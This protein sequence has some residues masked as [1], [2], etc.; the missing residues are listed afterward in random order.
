LSWKNIPNVFTFQTGTCLQD[1]KC[2]YW[3][4]ISNF[5]ITISIVGNL[6]RITDI[7]MIVVLF[8][9]I[10]IEC[11]LLMLR[12]VNVHNETTETGMSIIHTNETTNQMYV[13]LSLTLWKESLN[14]DG[15]NFIRVW[16]KL[17]ITSHLKSLNTK[18]KNLYIKYWKYMSRFGTGTKM[19]RG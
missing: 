9:Y 4:I 7:I 12:L 10:L 13:R 14:N 16:T 18:I 2:K 8:V 19:W 3:R 1:S 17:T 5:H 6:Q 11:L 15:N